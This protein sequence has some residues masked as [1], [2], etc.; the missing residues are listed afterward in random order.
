MDDTI[1]KDAA[2]LSV[3]TAHG[4]L[5]GQPSSMYLL[6]TMVQPAQVRVLDLRRGWYRNNCMEDLDWSRVTGLLS[7][8]AA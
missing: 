8:Y 6:S 5:A 1:H 7:L 4:L 3:T 2:A